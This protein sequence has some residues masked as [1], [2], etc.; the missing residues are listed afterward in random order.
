MRQGPA[1]LIA[2]GQRARS[3]FGLARIGLR[4]LGDNKPTPAPKP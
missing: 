2:V 1:R 3:A 4:H